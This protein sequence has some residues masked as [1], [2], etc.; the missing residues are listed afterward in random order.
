MSRSYK[1]TPIVK[2]ATSRVYKKI[3]NRQLRRCK[4]LHSGGWYKKRFDSWEIADYIC[5]ETYS[6]FK[7]QRREWNQW[8]ERM[9][10][11]PDPSTEKE[12]Y[13]EWYKIYKAK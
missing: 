2:M 13:L 7:E 3:Y 1:K 12:M 4:E 11:K 10:L 9:S 5:R 8:R 6:A